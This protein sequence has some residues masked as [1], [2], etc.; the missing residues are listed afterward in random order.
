MRADKKSGKPGAKLFWDTSEY[1]KIPRSKEFHFNDLLGIF[2]L[3]SQQK[4]NMAH[5]I[6][7]LKIDPNL[8]MVNFCYK[9]LMVE[10]LQTFL[11]F[12]V[13]AAIQDC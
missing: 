13:L 4:S 3:L 11:S 5:N 7:K 1:L 9:F 6:F 12:L 8:E 2:I 10:P